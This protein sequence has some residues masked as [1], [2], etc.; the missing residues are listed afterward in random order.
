MYRYLA[1]KQIP[2]LKDYFKYNIPSFQELCR[3]Y[4]YSAKYVEEW[5]H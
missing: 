3:Q 1:Y 4:S 2:T 5:G